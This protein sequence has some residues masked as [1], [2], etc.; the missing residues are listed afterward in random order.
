MR[1]ALVSFVGASVVLLTYNG[2]RIHFCFVFLGRRSCIRSFVDS[3]VEWHRSRPV[4][5][6]HLRCQRVGRNRKY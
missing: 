3:A 1:V 2:L 6:A 5:P 4:Q